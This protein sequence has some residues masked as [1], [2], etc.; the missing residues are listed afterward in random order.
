MRINGEKVR[1]ATEAL[2]IT[3][4]PK[5]VAKGDTKDPASCAAAQACM[6]E[7]HASAAR[8]HVART[9][10]K[11]G[12]EWVRYQTPAA[13]RSEI[14]AFDR[15][16]SFEPGDYSLRPLPKS[17]RV[18]RGKAHTTG[19]PKRGRKGHHRIKPH[20]TTGIRAHGANR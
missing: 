7:H 5:D 6:R 12:K 15:G 19:A 3:I 17:E 9:Y 14:V 13:L 2:K 11:I 18:K 10:L 16:G 4:T 8:V 1:D 20:V